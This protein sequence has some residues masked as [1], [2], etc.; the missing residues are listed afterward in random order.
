MAGEFSRTEMLIG[1]KGLETLANS[2]V[3]IFPTSWKLLPSVAWGA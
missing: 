2:C 1:R 3:M